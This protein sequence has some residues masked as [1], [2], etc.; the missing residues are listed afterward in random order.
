[1]SGIDLAAAGA[2][3]TV[4]AVRK[5]AA[6]TVRQYVE[7]LGQKY[8]NEVARSGDDSPRRGR[9]PPQRPPSAAAR[10]VTRR[11]SRSSVRRPPPA[12]QQNVR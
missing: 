11:P 2:G 9:P 1:M 8:P 3:G 6:D 5:G 4:R 7:A 10:A 12:P